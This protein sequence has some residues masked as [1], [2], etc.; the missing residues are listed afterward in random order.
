MMYNTYIILHS[1]YPK[2][3][4]Q[5]TCHLDGKYLLDPSSKSTWT[6]AGV[7]HIPANYSFLATTLSKKA[8]QDMGVGSR[9]LGF[10]VFARKKFCVKSSQFFAFLWILT[11]F[12][13]HL[14]FFDLWGVRTCLLHAEYI[15]LCR[16]CFW[17]GWLINFVIASDFKQD[18]CVLFA[19][20]VLLTY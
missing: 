9:F 17:W 2:N 14:M 13:A 19:R 18:F 7:K 16:V 8:T 10:N 4:K 12:C 20:I 1:K 5:K 11:L 3:T 6:C 15:T